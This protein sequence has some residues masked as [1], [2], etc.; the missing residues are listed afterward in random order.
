[1]AD[2]LRMKKK[3][4]RIQRP[5]GWREVERKKRREWNFKIYKTSSESTLVPDDKNKR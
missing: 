2:F 5:K 4:S 3:S 1:M